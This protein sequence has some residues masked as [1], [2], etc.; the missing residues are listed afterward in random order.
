[1][2]IIVSADHLR[3]MEA[4]GEHTYPNEGAGFLFGRGD[5]GSITIEAV[6][7]IDNKREVEAQYNRYQLGPEDFVKAEMAAAHLD[8]SLIG[9]FH[10]HPDHP[11]RPSQFDLDHA[12]PYFLYL[13]TSI[14]EGRAAVTTAWQLRLDR[15]AFDQDSIEISL[16]E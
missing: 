2:N 5:E 10:S 14:E 11:A 16:P 9:V 7:P 8:L 13:I 15:S 4:H 6:T 12:L 1:M 3:A